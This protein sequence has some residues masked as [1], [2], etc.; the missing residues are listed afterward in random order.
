MKRVITIKFTD[1]SWFKLTERMEAV[2]EMLTEEHTILGTS[3]TS[4]QG[5]FYGAI[6]HEPFES[7]CTTI[8][9][10]EDGTNTVVHSIS[11][12]LQEDLEPIGYPGKFHV[13]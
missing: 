13:G 6:F 8:E 5:L 2:L 3:I 1:G 4:A 7:D 12:Q 10:H 11:E 9:H